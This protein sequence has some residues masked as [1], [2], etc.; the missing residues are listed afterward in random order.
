MVKVREELTGR[1]FG[2]L[3]VLYQTNDYIDKNGKH[4]SNWECQCCCENKTILQVR[5]SQ[6]LKR[7]GTQSCGCIQKEIAKNTGIKNKKINKYDLSGEFGIGWT[8]NTNKEFYFDLEDYD[9]I[10]EYCWAE[11]KMSGRNYVALEA[12]DMKTNK[13]IRMSNLL[14]FKNYDHI[15]RNTLDNRKENL[16]EA[17]NRENSINKNKLPTNTSGV[18]G[19][20]YDKQTGMWV[21][22][23]NYKPNKRIVICRSCNKEDAIK[24]RLMA[25][26]KY[27]GNFAPQRHLFEQYGIK[28]EGCD[29]NES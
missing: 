18:I 22:R 4:Y 17:T 20:H 14:G 23:I 16:R 7:N 19:V 5:G 3:T 27:Y 28:Y 11:H 9:K 2:R 13:L 1:I 12:R 21:A 24:A 15:N 8:S 25:E 10:K 6:L 29:K 26:A